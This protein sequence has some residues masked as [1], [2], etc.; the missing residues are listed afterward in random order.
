MNIIV[1]PWFKTIGIRPS[2]FSNLMTNPILTTL[3]IEFVPDD[4]EKSLRW[5]TYISP[6]NLHTIVNE[7]L[8]ITVRPL[9]FFSLWQ[10]SV[11]VIIRSLIL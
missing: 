10:I 8:L 6:H 9:I 11:H 2:N 5:K 1:R 4:S 7:N 3:K